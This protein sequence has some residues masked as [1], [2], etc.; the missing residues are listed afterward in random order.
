MEVFIFRAT[1]YELRVT[2]FELRAGSAYRHDDEPNQ[3]VSH[4]N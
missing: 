1:S 3:G 4:E 2:R